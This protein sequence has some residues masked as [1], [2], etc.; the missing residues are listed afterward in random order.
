[1]KEDK[2]LIIIKKIDNILNEPNMLKAIPVLLVP[3]IFTV[4]IGFILINFLPNDVLNIVGFNSYISLLIMFIILL[5]S[6]LY[7]KSGL[8][9][10]ITVAI[11][12]FIAAYF[13]VSRVNSLTGGFVEPLSLGEALIQTFP[14]LPLIVFFVLYI[15]N[16]VKQP[17]SHLMN[18]VQRVSNGDLSV[19]E[20]SL[21]EFGTEFKDYEESFIKMV[22]NISTI[23]ST[24]QKTSFQISSASE[25]LSSTSE[26]VNA[27]S[28]EIA[29]TIQQVS[30]GASSQSEYS[31]KGT[32]DVRNMAEIVDRSLQDIE[33]TLKV[34]ED[35][36][37]QT[38]ILALNA[39]IEAARAGEYGRGFAVVAD[40]VRR[41]AEET[42]TNAADINKITE[43]VISNIG[44]SVKSLQE[45]L[46]GF[47]AQSEEFAA[48]S[49]EVAAAT[50]EQSSAMHQL[51]TSAQD[52]SKL[53]DE[54]V[55]MVGRF[56]T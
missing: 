25:E 28:E 38:N 45:T 24:T 54:L 44:K 47:S 7:F 36:A 20:S 43:A 11:V 35:I 19:Q 18:E 21:S 50:E 2:R 39:A 49:E 51:T 4:I 16:S 6:R 9:F 23:I 8:Y 15:G 42:K 29:A 27:L 37:G 55:D 12:I 10:R 56:K 31:V 33:T 30:R 26:E 52:L 40:N 48:S 34:I 5:I 3:T 53:S 13:L 46:Q 22:Q 17:L 41:L 32:E 14:M 1:M